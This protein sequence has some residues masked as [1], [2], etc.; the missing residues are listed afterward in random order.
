MKRPTTIEDIADNLGDITTYQAGIVQAS[1]HR[2]LQKLC[3]AALKPYGI[4]KMQWMIIGNVLDSGTKGARITDLAKLLG[5]TLPYLTT[6]INLLESKGIL[7]RVDNQ[8]DN[9]SKLVSVSTKFAKKTDE[10]EQALRQALRDTI[11]S[12]VEPKEFRIYMKVLYQ[13]YDIVE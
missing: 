13:M 10:I 5:T 9:R 8:K 1:V 7:V 2:A 11:Y 4:S 6:T 3:D 12:K